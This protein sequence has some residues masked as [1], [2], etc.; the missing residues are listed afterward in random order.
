MENED[1]GATQ[2][3]ASKDKKSKKKKGGVAK[4]NVDEIISTD[5]PAKTP[6]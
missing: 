6:K 1:R 3:A 4:P 2:L 5:E